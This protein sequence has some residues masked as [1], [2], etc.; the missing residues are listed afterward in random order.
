MS[1]VVKAGSAVC[2]TERAFRLR[3]PSPYSFEFIVLTAVEVL[4]LPSRPGVGERPDVAHSR[5]VYFC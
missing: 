1:C 5:G 3:A 2:F 4:E